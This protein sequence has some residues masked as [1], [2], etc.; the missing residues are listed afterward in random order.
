MKRLVLLLL[1]G[2]VLL[3]TRVA[4][5]ALLFG[6]SDTI[7]T[8]AITAQATHDIIFHNPTTIPASGKIIFTPTPGQFTIPGG[9]Y[10]RD[11]DLLINGVN[12]PLNNVPG[13]GAGSAHGVSVI[14]GTNG[15]ITITLND[16]DSITSGST[17]EIIIGPGAT[18]GAAGVLGITNPGSIGSQLVS[19]ETAD[20]LNV[21]LDTGGI[22]LAITIPVGITADNTN[23]AVDAP[24]IN[25]PSGAYN[26][27]VTVT[28]ATNTVGASIYYTLD[29]TTPTNLSTLYTGSFSINQSTAVKAIGIKSGLQDSGVS[30]GNYTITHTNTESH[31]PGEGG[32]MPPVGSTTINGSTGGTATGQCSTG[33]G[34][35][36][37]IAPGSWTG[38]GIVQLSCSAWSTFTPKTGAPQDGQA[39]AD[40]VFGIHVTTSA[41]AQILT[42]LKP[43][44]VNLF[45][46]PGQRQPFT[47]QL[48]AFNFNPQFFWRTTENKIQANRTEYFSLSTQRLEPITVLGRPHTFTCTSINADLNCDG[49]VN[50]TDFS[51]LMYYWGST[52]QGLKADINK[53]GI[54]NLID[55]SILLYWWTN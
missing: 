40:T 46:T 18:Y 19:V 42:S 39:I 4:A 41:G 16:S 34:I 14:S 49:K 26:N 29:G 5:A 50:N 11:V 2:L 37:L 25:P 22:G 36:L 30:T 38:V 51:I 54:V 12:Q 47:D 44:T 32:Y 33:A 27:N 6:R 13:N 45:Y 53:D 15:N 43:V 23:A 28:L 20:N 24:S 10:Y 21:P 52:R 31:T 1:L 7:S 48:D 8:S 3:Q 55:F 35:S 9:L 17:V